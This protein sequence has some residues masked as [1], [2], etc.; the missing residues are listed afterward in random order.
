MEPLC[1]PFETCLSIERS[2]LTSEF[3]RSLPRYCY[4]LGNTYKGITPKVSGWWFDGFP[5][6]WR[7]ISCCAF[8]LS[9]DRDNIFCLYLTLQFHEFL[10]CHFWRFRFQGKILIRCN[11]TSFCN[12]IFGGTLLVITSQILKCAL[13]FHEICNVTFGDSLLST[14]SQFSLILKRCSFTSFLQH[15][16]LAVMKKVLLR[17][18][19]SQWLLLFVFFCS[20]Q[21]GSK[22]G[23]I[24]V[25]SVKFVIFKLYSCSFY[26][27]AHL[28]RDCRRVQLC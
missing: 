27:N 10:Q 11:F 6:S 23:S 22:V 19:E 4:L 3:L 2:R 20:S 7:L 18:S 13:K 17:N 12:V 8:E 26:G 1:P 25:V 16:F 28:V 15:H 5:T 24:L 21:T 14:I 9:L